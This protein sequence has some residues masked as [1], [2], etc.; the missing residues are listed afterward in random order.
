M[1]M[2]G[3]RPAVEENQRLLGAIVETP[4]G[5]WFFKATGPDATMQAQRGNFKAL[6]DTMQYES[7]A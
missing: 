2:R 6:L 5:A 7:G 4:Q 3:D 1:S